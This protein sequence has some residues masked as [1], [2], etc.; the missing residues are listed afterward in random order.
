MSKGAE[1]AWVTVQG[2]S[3]LRLQMS[4]V[5]SQTRQT[6][7]G[8]AMDFHFILQTMGIHQWVSATA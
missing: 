7:V 5:R 3:E 2:E 6:R 8:H 1:G 4:I